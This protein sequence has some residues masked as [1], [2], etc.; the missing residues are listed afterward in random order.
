MSVPRSAKSAG[1]PGQVERR[2]SRWLPVPF[3]A[4]GIVLLASPLAAQ[5]VRELVLAPARVTLEAGN[6][7]LLVASSYDSL[8]NL[9]LADSISYRSTDTT[10]V[11]VSPAGELTAL[12]V[13]VAQIEARAGSAMA[14]VE[15]TVSAPP[16]PPLPRGTRGRP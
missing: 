12:Q 5:E 7:E 6:R 2:L 9:V 4:L 1:S 13:G 3:L 15:V 11:R 16:P 8:G 14:R 10:V